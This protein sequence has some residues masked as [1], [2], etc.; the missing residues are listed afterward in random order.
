[1]YDICVV[2]V[3]GFPETTLRS[4]VVAVCCVIVVR[5]TGFT[6]LSGIGVGRVHVVFK[7][8]WVFVVSITPVVVGV[9]TEQV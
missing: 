2:C 4:V 3:T 9:V 7:R 5:V 6:V 1:M 8:V